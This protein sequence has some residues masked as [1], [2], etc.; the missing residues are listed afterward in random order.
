[1]DMTKDGQSRRDVLKK[2]VYVAPV[3][4]TLPAAR[5]QTR[6]ASGDFQPPS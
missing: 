5:A 3:I 2:I 4:L 6:P 1:M